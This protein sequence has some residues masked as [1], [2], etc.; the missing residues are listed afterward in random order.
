MPVSIPNAPPG[1]GAHLQVLSVD[2]EKHGLVRI[3]DNNSSLVLA[4]QYVQKLFLIVTVMEL[5][6]SL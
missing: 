4:A 1:S 5:K 6:F 2:E 3:V